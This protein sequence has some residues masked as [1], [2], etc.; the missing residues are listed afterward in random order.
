MVDILIPGEN[1]DYYFV[2]LDRNA[3]NKVSNDLFYWSENYAELLRND[4]ISP[5]LCKDTQSYGIA[6]SKK[7]RFYPNKTVADCLYDFFDIAVASAE[8]RGVNKALVQD[9]VVVNGSGGG[10]VSGLIQLL[11][12]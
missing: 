6:F 3:L 5:I 11:L 12:D 4:N 7:V 2:N 10:S 9:I 8:K 1:Q